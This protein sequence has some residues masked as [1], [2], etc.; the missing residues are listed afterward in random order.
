MKENL[1]L[2]FS[3]NNYLYGINT[4]YVEEIFT[5]PE[6]TTIL[7]VPQGIIGFVNVRGKILP[8]IDLNLKLGYLSPD[9]RLTDSVVVLKWEDLQ[10]GMIVNQIHEIREISLEQITIEFNQQQELVIVEQTNI[11]AGVVKF[12]D[13]I[14]ILSNPRKWLADVEKQQLLSWQ[15]NLEQEIFE[16]NVSEIQ[17]NNSELLLLQNP[18]F[19]PNATLEERKVFKQ[20]ADNLRLS[21]KTQDFKNFKTLAVIALNDY[22]FGIDLEMVREFIDIHQVTPIPCCPAHIIGNM[23]LRGEIL[24]LVDLRGVLLN[25]PPQGVV[26]GSKA[27]V[28]EVEGIVAGVIVEEIYDVMFSLNLQKVTAIPKTIHGINEQYCQGAAPYYEKIMNILDMPKIFLQSELIVDE[29]I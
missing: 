18:K 9:Y 26:V 28:I 17:T 1:Y 20:R 21:T 19:C 11:I 3:L 16:N 7:E 22:L 25:F 24:T 6:L 29:A 12:P 10:L 4:V 5:L 8:I 2:T 23:N 13:E 27:M 14:F 15:N